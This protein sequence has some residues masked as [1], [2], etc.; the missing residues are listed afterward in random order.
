MTAVLQRTQAPEKVVT[1][2][3]ESMH[4]VVI[5]GGGFGGLY[6]AKSLGN[7]R[8]FVPAKVVM[9]DACSHNQAIVG[10]N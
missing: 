6:A 4:H 8:P 1:G 5:I 10:H 3:S 9:T 2:P 7:V